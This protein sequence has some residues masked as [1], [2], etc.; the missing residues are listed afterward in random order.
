MHME[1]LLEEDTA[2]DDDPAEN[3]ARSDAALDVT[4]DG[5]E[6]YSAPEDGL[7]TV[8]DGVGFQ[9]RPAPASGPVL[10][11]N[12]VDDKDHGFHGLCG[13]SR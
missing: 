12:L 13:C 5:H 4:L 10:S 11:C 6:D 2:S 3:A 1:N 7:E 9:G 8:E